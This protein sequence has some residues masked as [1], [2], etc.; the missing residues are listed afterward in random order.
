M[1]IYDIH[2][3]NNANNRRFNNLKKTADQRSD[4]EVTLWFTNFFAMQ[5]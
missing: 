5:K 1:Y 3:A 4:F 2:P